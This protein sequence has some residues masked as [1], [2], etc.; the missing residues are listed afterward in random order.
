[1]SIFNIFGCQDKGTDDPYWEFER[2]KHFRP[3]LNKGDFFKLSG[4]DFGWFVLE[5]LSKFVKDR[6][7]EIEKGKSLSYG[8]K[9]LYYW[10]YL[11]AQVTNGGFVQFYYNGYAPYVQTIIKG[12]E[13]IGDNKMVDL[14]KRADKIYQKNLKLMKKAQQE[15]LFGSDLYE[16]LDELSLLDDEYYEL[17][18]NTMTLIESYIRKNP[19]EICLDENGKEFDMNFTG[20]CKTFYDDKAVKEEFNLVK[21]VIT[22]EFNSYYPN[23]VNK[24]KID[25]LNG[26][27]TGEREEFYDNSKLKY[28]GTVAP[29]KKHTVHKWF[30][31]NGNPKKLETKLIEKDE[32]QG[33]Y[34]EWYENG[35]LAESGTYISGYERDGEWLEFY[36]D[37]SKKVEAEFKN[38]EF[39]LNNCWNEKGEQTLTNGTGLYIKEYSMSKDR[40]YRNEHEYKN[41]KRHGIQKTFTNGILTLYQEM[42]NG[43]THGITK[44]YYDNGNIE[45]ETVYENG[46]A[47]SEK[48]YSKFKNPKVKT[49]ILSR[50]CKNCYDDQEEYIIPDNE[51]N[52]INTEELESK[53]KGAEVSMFEPYGDDHE[54]G[55]SYIVYV[56]EEGNVTESKFWAA[57]NA[58]IAEQ[59][60][61]NI[62]KIKFEP[63][64]KDNKP[65]K[66]IH[67]VQH[68]FKL[69]E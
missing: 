38:G 68:K 6:E 7:H 64:I 15:D 36:E 62:K 54:M 55:Y 50:L 19:N 13:Y 40:L 51:P 39:I 32:R 60:E 61:S 29:S 5:P 25:Y 41:H 28:Q 33:E 10:W 30:Y 49:T 67:F 57:D 35:Q 53:F 58:W 8:Q 17:N 56:D 47:I 23:G 65:I 24:E 12:L 69:I 14:V 59:V 21:G 20:I 45:K 22:G 18:E 43:K 4:Y 42:A 2:S 31:E 37:G 34:K 63:A 3:K 48:K 66:S 46:K 27:Q 44:N 11:D 26:V 9:T 1:M 52:P 16:R